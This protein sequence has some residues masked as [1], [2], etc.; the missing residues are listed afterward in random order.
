MEDS[1][2]THPASSLG[3]QPPKWSGW[4]IREYMTDPDFEQ[5][6][7]SVVKAWCGKIG[8]AASPRLRPRC[9]SSSPKRSP[10][11]LPTIFGGLLLLA[12]VLFLGYAVGI[13][14]EWLPGSRVSVPKPVALDQ[15]RPTVEPTRAL[16]P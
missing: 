15:P 5:G 10:F 12:G 6:F 13:Y 2:A 9:V 7:R 3:G 8:I 11:G 4:P 1:E 16:P 14:M